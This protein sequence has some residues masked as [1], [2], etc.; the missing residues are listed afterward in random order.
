[1]RPIYENTVIQIEITN[2][3]HL[4]CANCT[5]F[6]GHHRKPF[7]MSV[8]HVRAAIASL[9]EFPGRVGIMGGE[10]TMHPKFREILQV[11]REMIPDKGRREFWTAGFKWDEFRDDIQLTFDRI[12]YNDHTQVTGKHQPLLVGID[13]VIK[14]PELR[15]ILIDNC[16]V[17]AQWSASITPKGAFFCEIA[18]A[19]DWLFN[20]PGGYDVVPG[21][22]DKTPD[23]FQDQV[24]RYC[25][26]CSAAIPMQT[27]SDARG[28][29]E[30]SIDVI[31]PKNLERL[32]RVR[33][34]KVMA[35]KYRIQAEPMDTEQYMASWTPSKFR[36]FVAHNPEDVRDALAKREVTEGDQVQHSD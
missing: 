35:G 33:S 20:G 26:Q 6:V 32:K 4:A 23:D 14:D 29:R 2:A 8:D 9:E 17:Q 7:F 12:A 11:V 22:W 3:C 15:K 19:Q 30:K 18:A 36:P 24:A 16:W 28:G 27:E 13:E 31:S 21:W 1:M 25:G 10:P 5:R 34:P